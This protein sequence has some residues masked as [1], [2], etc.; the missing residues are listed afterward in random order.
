MDF[1]LAAKLSGARF[2]V[3]KKGL[4]RL[5][6]ALGQFMLDVHTSEPHN[7]TEVSPPLLV[8]DE[9]MFGTAQLPKFEDDQFCACELKCRTCVNATRKIF[10][11]CESEADSKIERYD[12]L[13]RHESRATRFPG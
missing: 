5:E 8:R 1:E 4:A 2:V 12:V 10:S 13:S 9:V 11:D 7:Y 6:R 3:L